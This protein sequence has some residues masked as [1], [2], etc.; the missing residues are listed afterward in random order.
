MVFCIVFRCSQ[1]GDKQKWVLLKAV[2]SLKR[3]SVLL[4]VRRSSL[5]EEGPLPWPGW[6]T[7]TKPET[8]IRQP[9]TSSHACYVVTPTTFL[10]SVVLYVFHHFNQIC[11]QRKLKRAGICSRS[12]IKWIHS[13]MTTR[14]WQ[15]DTQCM[16]SQE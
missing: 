8:R 7:D 2:E 1:R 10:L 14:A 3:I 12:W 5:L 16:C 4:R 11:T 6:P 9:E 13:I 15:L